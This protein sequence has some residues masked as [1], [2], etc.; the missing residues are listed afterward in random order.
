MQ[1]TLLDFT[2]ACADD[3]GRYAASI[4]LYTKSTRLQ[5]SPD[6]L[7]EIKEKP[8]EEIMFNLR[9]MADTN[10][11]SWEFVYLTFFIE[12]ATRALQQQ[13]TR[14]RTASYA[15]QTT[16]LVNM[17]DFEYDIGPSIANDVDRRIIYDA[18]MNEINKAYKWLVRQGAEIEDI[19]G[20]LPLNVYSN[21]NMSINF[22]NWVNLVRKRESLRVQTP[23][24]KMLDMMVMEVEKVYPWAWMFIKNDE[25][26]ARKDLQLMIYENKALSNED[27]TTMIKKLDIIMKEL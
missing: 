24:R 19:R 26:K 21:I 3:P 18:A 6:L 15:I 4:L 1:V 11:G 25:M 10:P 7:Q 14:T 16:R 23:Y 8:D 13:L 5:M 20:M 17:S 27:K 22:R 2:G 12:G 9:L